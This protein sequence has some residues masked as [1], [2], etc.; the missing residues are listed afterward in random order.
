MKKS[1][2]D[3]VVAVLLIATA[4]LLL[5]IF[6]V[7]TG[8]TYR[9]QQHN[10]TVVFLEDRI[11][12]FQEQRDLM[13]ES[14]RAIEKDLA[15]LNQRIQQLDVEIENM[16]SHL[17][18]SKKSMKAPLFSLHNFRVSATTGLIVIALL[19]FIWVLYKMTGKDDESGEPLSKEEGSDQP[20]EEP[21]LSAVVMAE[22]AST[23]DAA[24]DMAE[25]SHSGSEPPPPGE[26]VGEET[27]EPEV[28][29]EEQGEKEN[30]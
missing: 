7:R 9:L 15:L 29:A 6:V 11:S 21:V 25:E 30:T 27:D 19:V 14:S 5:Y 17:T 8:S 10:G 26:T 16:R 20:R 23:E 12:A 3:G 2:L 1:A 28:K 22:K 18:S 4:I 13:R 24:P